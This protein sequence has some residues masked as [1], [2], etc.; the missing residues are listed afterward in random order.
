[1]LG[2]YSHVEVWGYNYCTAMNGLARVRL[3]QGYAIDNPARSMPRG[4][5]RSWVGL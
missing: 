3:R 4:I 5:T 1:M 2:L